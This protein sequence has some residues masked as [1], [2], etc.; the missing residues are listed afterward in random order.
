MRRGVTGSLC[1]SPWLTS[2][3]PVDLMGHEMRS[4][5]NAPFALMSQTSQLQPWMEP[6]QL[7]S[8]CNCFSQSNQTP[9]FKTIKLLKTASK[10][11]VALP[12]V[13]MTGPFLKPSSIKEG[14][15]SRELLV[16][17]T[18]CPTQMTPNANAPA[19]CDY[20]AGPGVTVEGRMAAL[21]R[22]RTQALERKPTNFNL[23]PQ[24]S[25]AS[26]ELMGSLWR[27]SFW[28]CG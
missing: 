23:P 19:W 21:G 14:L 17:F 28:D 2:S 1:H 26:L 6:A 24:V 11:G 20:P 15:S 3:Y 25:H 4:E 7:Q 22:S 5:I 9:F 27:P 12:E 13:S 10:N 18:S 16:S 8:F